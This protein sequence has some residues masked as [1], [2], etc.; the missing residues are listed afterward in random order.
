MQ[1]FLNVHIVIWL[2][3]VVWKWTGFGTRC[4]LI[5][6]LHFTSP[7]S[8]VSCCVLSVE[9]RLQ[10]LLALPRLWWGPVHLDC[11]LAYNRQEHCL[12][13]LCWLPP[14]AKRTWRTLPAFWSLLIILKVISHQFIWA[15]SNVTWIP[16]EIKPGS[17]SIPKGTLSPALLNPKWPGKEVATG[18]ADF[19]KSRTNGTKSRISVLS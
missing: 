18:Y 11:G 3:S 4:A 8:R 6:A 16:E 13:A 5:L 17:D 19:K 1:H 15:Q 9:W 14:S 2:C 12:L 10:L 7:V